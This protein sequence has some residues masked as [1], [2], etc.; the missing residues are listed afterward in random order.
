MLFT[1][2][3]VSLA[4]LFMILI[5]SSCLGQKTTQITY[6]K[7][8]S[9]INGWIIELKPESTTQIKTLDGSIIVINTSD[10]IKITSSDLIQLKS[11]TP[12][13]QNDFILPK[14]CLHFGA[15]I[16]G[17]FH[18]RALNNSTYSNPNGGANASAMF[19]IEGNF[20]P[21][22]SVFTGLKLNFFHTTSR[23]LFYKINEPFLF[24]VR[25][26]IPVGVMI[27]S[28]FVNNVRLLTS[29]SYTNNL[30]L[31]TNILLF[32][33]ENG[34][35]QGLRNSYSGGI[36]ISMGP[37]FKVGYNSMLA[38]MPYLSFYDLVKVPYR[39]KSPTGASIETIQTSIGLNVLYIIG[40]PR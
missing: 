18:V 9:V 25:L 12:T 5:Y 36:D 31:A 6:T 40:Y 32:K 22:I 17:S 27:K 35:V 24:S 8:G 38:I 15:G 2:K 4:L 1:R 33:N 10:I 39:P 3:K 11:K 19:L 26:G 28:N 37:Q 20:H 16:G 13:S 29:V 14:V 34:Q 23:D 30:A 7:N 21:N